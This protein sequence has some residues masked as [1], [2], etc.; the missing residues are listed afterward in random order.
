TVA[1]Q[2][3]TLLNHDLTRTQARAL[4]SRLLRDGGTEDAARIERAYLLLFA[5][6]PRPEEVLLCR[7]LL[8]SAAG[9]TP[10]ERWQDL[11]HVLLCSNEFAYLE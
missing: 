11:A 1:P 9:V 10:E 2:A 8:L 7:R 3:L 5:R 6:P 4:A